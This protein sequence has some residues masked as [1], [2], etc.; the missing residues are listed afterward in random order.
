MFVL[1]NPRP[2]CGRSEVRSDAAGWRPIC[3]ARALIIF[4]LGH[5]GTPRWQA[6]CRHR[7]DPPTTR[8][9]ARQ[10]T[11][12]RTKFC[13]KHY[14]PLPRPSSFA[15]TSAPKWGVGD[16][17]APR[18]RPIGSLAKSLPPCNQRSA[19]AMFP[20]QQETPLRLL[21]QYRNG[22]RG[23][24]HANLRQPWRKHSTLVG[25]SLSVTAYGVVVPNPVAQP[26]RALAPAVRSSNAFRSPK[27]CTV[28]RAVGWAGSTWTEK[29]RLLKNARPSQSP[30]ENSDHADLCSRRVNSRLGA[31]IIP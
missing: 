20:L 4:A 28:P 23:T 16:E 30:M 22:A 9:A 13:Q 7:H 27:R 26:Q 15:E 31:T 17:P 21:G 3:V 5:P 12:R 19:Q 18:P 14:N 1:V 24:T 25:Q 8:A 2:L 10:P 11:N 6:A 29:C